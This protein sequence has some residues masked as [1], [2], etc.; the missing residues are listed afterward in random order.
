MAWV[1]AQTNP[2]L[3]HSYLVW[4]LASHN[5]SLSCYFHAAMF[6]YIIFYHRL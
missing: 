1:A 2:N 4:I 6:R 5:L 3:S